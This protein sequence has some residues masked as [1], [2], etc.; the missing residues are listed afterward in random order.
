[1]RKRGFTTPQQYFW[2]CFLVLLSVVASLLLVLVVAIQ[3]RL[4]MKAEAEAIARKETNILSIRQFDIFHGQATYYS[5]FGL[6][7]AG[8]EIVVV[9]DKETKETHAF[10]ISNGISRQEA[11]AIATE[12]GLLPIE[13]VTFG[14]VNGRPVWEVLSEG[15]YYQIDFKTGT[16][17]EDEE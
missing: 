5:V 8:H 2:G 3:P 12:E 15:Q 14:M 17:K 1:M 10:R 4:D 16:M 11:E 6:D 9:I 13:K 7:K